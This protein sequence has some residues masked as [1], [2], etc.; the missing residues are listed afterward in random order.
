MMPFR[1]TKLIAI[2]AVGAALVSVLLYGALWFVFARER[3]AQDSETRLRAIALHER[4]QNAAL[5]ALLA[6]TAEKRARADAFFVEGGGAVSFLGEIE[7]VGK[8]AGVRTTIVNVARG[9]RTDGA[10]TRAA[11]G[12]GEL[13]VTVEARGSFSDVYR[14]L[15]L[16]EELPRP[17]TLARASFSQGEGGAWSGLFELR[18]LQNQ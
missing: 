13:V 17:V 3:V 8:H 14:F 1:S 4:T 9:E 16:T 12:V 2:I 7:R 6:E 15:A 10:N 18:A 5:T 11:A